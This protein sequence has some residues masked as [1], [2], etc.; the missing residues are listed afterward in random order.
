MASSLLDDSDLASGT[1]Q[2]R[3]HAVDAVGNERTVSMWPDG[4]AVEVQLPVRA[5]TSLTAGVA[6]KRG[7]LETH[8]QVRFASKVPLVGR[9]SD[10][11]GKARGGVP[12]EISERVAGSEVKWRSIGRV[13]TDKNGAFRYS[14]PR[15]PARTIRF[16]YA[17]TPLSRPAAAE[18]TLRVRAATTLTSSRRSLRNGETVV[19]GGRL[20]GRP[21]PAS[22]KVVTVQAR[23]GRG[24]L[25]F[26]TARAR[27]RDG[28]WSYRYT[29]TGTSTTVRYRFRAVVLQEE[30]YPYA[31][32]ISPTVSVLV[33]G[34]R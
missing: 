2:L 14:A 25:T 20:L 15:G 27:S 34:G 13:T 30:A 31:R 32:G 26:G 23:T 28:R 11:F 24:W 7:G 18:V 33:R 16:Q 19:L 6:A 29:F 17:G 12:V 8:P 5:G 9:V 3:A 4:R 21:V 1:Y 10:A 22:G